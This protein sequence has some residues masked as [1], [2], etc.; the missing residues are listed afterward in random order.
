MTRQ[1]LHAGFQPD[2]GTSPKARPT[3]HDFRFFGY[4]CGIE[5]EW[6][7]FVLSGLESVRG[8]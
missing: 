2:L 1:A 8:Q 5:E 3:K 6:G 7:Y 4:V